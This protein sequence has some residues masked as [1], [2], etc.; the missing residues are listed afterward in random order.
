M[1][2]NS[3]QRQS[4]FLRAIVAT[5]VFV[6]GVASGTAHAIAITLDNPDQTVVRP[7]SGVTTVDFTGHIS[8]DDGFDGPGYIAYSAMTATGDFLQFPLPLLT[9]NTDGILFSLQVAATD[10]L[11]LYNLNF[12]SSPLFLQIYE[13]PRVSGECP[14]AAVNYSLNVVAAA[15]PEPAT[16]GLLAIGCVGF[17]F[18]RR[19]S[20]INQALKYWRTTN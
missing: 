11:G 18:V 12:F 3:N 5:A 14:G 4:D 10:A 9:F 20:R 6:A 2:S 13:C 8:I 1:V 15:V 16:F 7:T 17:V 19:I